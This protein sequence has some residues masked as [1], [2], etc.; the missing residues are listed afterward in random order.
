MPTI[1]S[2]EDDLVEVE[3][4]SSV[5][6]FVSII[7]ESVAP[8]EA[9]SRMEIDLESIP[10]E[11][12]GSG[13]IQFSVTLSNGKSKNEY[14]TTII[15]KDESGN[16]TQIGSQFTGSSQDPGEG[17]SEGGPSIKITKVSSLGL[18]TV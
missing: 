7:L 14:T 18:V 11:D 16:A 13:Q 12:V 1:F 17:D 4:P 9:S 5:A 3:V 10:P 6:G 2:F 15:F 8:G